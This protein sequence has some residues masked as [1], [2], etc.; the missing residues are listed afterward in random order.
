[1]PITVAELEAYYGKDSPAPSPAPSSTSTSEN[2]S[3]ST[4][5]SNSCMI[6]YVTLKANHLLIKTKIANGTSTSS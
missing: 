1:M 6:Y 4:S 5:T 2:S 3:G